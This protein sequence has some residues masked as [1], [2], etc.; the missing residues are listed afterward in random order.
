MPPSPRHP[1]TTWRA[2]IV[3][4]PHSQAAVA[5]AIQISAKHLS[6]IV[7]GR[8]L[9]SPTVTRRFAELLEVDPDQLWREVA[10]YKLANAPDGGPWISSDGDGT[11]GPED[12]HE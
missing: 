5:I 7:N 2:L 6:Q 3:H 1:G 9:P 8:A 11:H 12:D 4:S 10:R